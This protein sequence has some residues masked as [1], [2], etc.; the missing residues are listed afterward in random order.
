MVMPG[1]PIVI[2]D[3][4]AQHTPFHDGQD[5]ALAT[6]RTVDAAVTRIRRKLG[7]Y[8]E[9]LVTRGAGYVFEE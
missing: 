5:D 7:P 4:A 2:V 8:A 9:A 6:S 1:L 3:G